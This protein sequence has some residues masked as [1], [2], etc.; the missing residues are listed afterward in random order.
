MAVWADYRHCPEY[1]EGSEGGAAIYIQRFDTSGVRLGNNIR[2]DE[3]S[4]GDISNT[5]PDIA[6]SKTCGDFVI[7]WQE[8]SDSS[9][10]SSR[11]TSRI[12]ANIFNV[13]LV[14]VAFQFVVLPNDTMRQAFPEARYLS[15]NNILILWLEN[16]NGNQFYYA[17]L[18]DSLGVVVREK[19]KVNSNDVSS[20]SVFFDALPSSGFYFIWDSYIQMYDNSGNSVTDI[21]EGPFENVNAV[22]S[23]NE[24]DILIICRDEFQRRLEGVIYKVT[25]NSYSESFRIDDDTTTLNTRGGCDVALNQSGDF[26]VVWR[27]SRNDYNNLYDVSDV[28][29]QRFDYEAHPIGNNFKINHEDTEIEQHYP[30]V[31]FYNNRF[32]TIFLQGEVRESTDDLSDDVVDVNESR[33]D[34]VG[35]SQNFTNPTPGQVYGWRYLH[36]SPP[37]TFDA[38]RQPYP[39]PFI[40]EDHDFVAIEFNLDKEARVSCT[41]Y[42]MLGQHIKTLLSSELLSKG[43][44]VAKWYGDTHNGGMVNSG[45]YFCVFI[46]NGKAFNKKITLIKN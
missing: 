30:K 12:I 34:I 7:V 8:R 43:F 1:G 31:S 2:M 27:D 37:D 45:V 25:Q 20:S 3:K 44:Y 4:D 36:P 17:K 22:R 40:K 18:F 10:F 32:I 16:H 15:N 11:T 13:D 5:N 46:I 38:S 35:T 19:F 42:N 23:L 28:Y 41:I 24:N 39:N 29:G 33:S 14:K 21:L 6:I 26:I 9:T